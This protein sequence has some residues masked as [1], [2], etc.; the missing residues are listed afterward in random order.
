MYYVSYYVLCL[1]LK[2]NILSCGPLTVVAFLHPRC[3]GQI[4]SVA[5]EQADGEDDDDDDRDVDDDPDDDD[6]L[7]H[8]D[9]HCTTVERCNRWGVSQVTPQ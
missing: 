9:H 2:C 7:D 6:D 5:A 4:I 8:D 1:T 3:W